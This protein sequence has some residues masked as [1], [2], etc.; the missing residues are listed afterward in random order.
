MAVAVAVKGFR[1]FGKGSR[2]ILFPEGESQ[3]LPLKEQFRLRDELNAVRQRVL[4]NRAWV[5]RA[6]S[7]L[8]R[9]LEEKS[10]GPGLTDEEETLLGYSNTVS[11]NN[12]P[13]SH[14]S[15]FRREAV[16]RFVLANDEKRFKGRFTRARNKLIEEY[17]ETLAEKMAG[18]FIRDRIKIR[19]GLGRHDESEFF[20]A[21]YAGLLHAAHHYEARDFEGYAKNVI[22][23]YLTRVIIDD[24][25]KH[26]RVLKQP[27]P[28]EL[29]GVEFHRT[30]VGDYADARLRSSLVP[31]LQKL[32][33][34]GYSRLPL[35]LDA[36]G[37]N[38]SGVPLNHEELATAYGLSR[39]AVKSALWRFKHEIAPLLRRDPRMRALRDHARELDF[40]RSVVLKPE[41][42]SR[43]KGK[44]RVT[45]GS[46]GS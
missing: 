25:R 18:A 37:L 3:V 38:G 26:G 27:V 43:V 4:R 23:D 36:F 30:P 2:A 41:R 5:Q 46:L 12:S 14:R 33:P 8:K 13:R 28:G 35:I 31:L 24:Y 6:Q 21:A 44:S 1:A 15:L 11:K 45:A 19:N 22:G 32:L 7:E 9:E 29:D 39:S 16:L 40:S 17:T 20:R 34:R 42:K 10:K